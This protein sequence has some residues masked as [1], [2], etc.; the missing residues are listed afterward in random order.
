M[1]ANMLGLG[2]MLA[3]IQDPNFQAHIKAI[4]DAITATNARCERLER[5]IDYLVSVS[6]RYDGSNTPTVSVGNGV[7]GT[8]MPAATGLAPDDGT[9]L[10]PA[11]AR[12]V[13][14]SK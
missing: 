13:G 14:N 5:K 2:P 8:G 4:V 9:R 3:T 6:D 11:P 12:R 10:G 1:W 7:D